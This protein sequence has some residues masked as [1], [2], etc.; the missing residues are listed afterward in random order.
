V[1]AGCVTLSPG[2]LV[3]QLQE[4]VRC[5]F[6]LLVAPFRCPVMA[7]FS[8]ARSL[9]EYAATRRSFPER[10]SRTPG[11]KR[12]HSRSDTAPG[13][14]VRFA[15]AALSSAYAMAST[16]AAAH[17]RSSGAPSSLGC[18]GGSPRR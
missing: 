2:R 13:T 8:T 18:S 4:L 9:R 10:H 16:T 3:K 12:P 17:P 7:A 11:R 15:E 1:V 14:R 6:D 5:E